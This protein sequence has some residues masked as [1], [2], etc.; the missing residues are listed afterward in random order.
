MLDAGMP[1]WS[2]D[3]MSALYVIQSQGG[4][5]AITNT[6]TEV[7]GKSPYSFDRFA[8]DFAAQFQN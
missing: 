8:T 5:A 7:T 1:E 3:I 4:A 6:V 2:T